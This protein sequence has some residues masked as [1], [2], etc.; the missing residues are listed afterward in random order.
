[1]K[2]SIIIPV[3]NVEQ[4]LRKCL[5]SVL[6]QSY[7]ADYEV[8]CVNDGSTDGSLAI[9]EEYARQHKKIK[10]INQANKG[11]SEARNAG[12]RAAQ[13]EYVWFVDSDD[14]IEHNAL[15]ILH[16]NID[17][18]DIICFNGKRYFEDGTQET[19]DKGIDIQA[20]SGWE[21]YNRYALKTSKF[22]FVCVVL[23]AYKRNFLLS[24]NLFFEPGIYHEDNLFTPITLYQAKKVKSIPDYL[25]QYRIRSGSITQNINLKRITDTIIIANR[26]AEFFI[27]KTDI[28]K[29]VVYR[30]IAG[31]YFSAFLPERAKI[32]G[33]DYKKVCSL[34]N[35]ESYR[36]VS[37][38]PRHRII[39]RLIS[40]SPKLFHWYLKLEGIIKKQKQLTN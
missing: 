15:E 28:D 19:P 37:Q 34:M 18:E 3:Y 27:P 22:H 38:Y 39:Y 25:Y 29:T 17:N 13:G 12:L 40:I 30:E 8:I 1:M 35:W 10:T 7:E 36:E 26:L 20:I 24:N 32:Y 2:F 6:E 9:L 14:W 31:E 16:K 4:Y 33:F 21:Y 11:L 23:R 5:D